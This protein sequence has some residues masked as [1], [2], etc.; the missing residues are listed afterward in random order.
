MLRAAQPQRAGV[1]AY[2]FA[3][4]GVGAVLLALMGLTLAN[5]SPA[6]KA[7]VGSVVR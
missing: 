1:E 4:R 5:T 2:L 3:L 6:I 7:I